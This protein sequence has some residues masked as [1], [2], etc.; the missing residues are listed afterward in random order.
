MNLEVS[1]DVNIFDLYEENERLRHQLEE[2]EKIIEEANNLLSE[3]LVV[4]EGNIYRPVKN[5]FSQD[6]YKTICMLNEILK[7]PYRRNYGLLRILDNNKVGE[8]NE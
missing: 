8:N 3:I 6:V 5:T 2:K 7:T 1:I 4:K